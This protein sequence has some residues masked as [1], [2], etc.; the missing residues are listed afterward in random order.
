MQGELVILGVFAAHQDLEAVAGTVAQEIGGFLPLVPLL[1][2]FQ[3]SLALQLGSDLVAGMFTGS[4]VHLIQDLS[5]LHISK[6]MSIPR[7]ASTF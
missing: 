6:Q 7:I 5:L 1:E 4:R 2:V 3:V